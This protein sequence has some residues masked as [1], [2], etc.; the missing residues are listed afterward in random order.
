MTFFKIKLRFPGLTALS[1]QPG[2]SWRQF[3]YSFTCPSTQGAR[4][5]A[6]SQ[7]RL[8][9][10]PEQQ[11]SSSP[12]AGSELHLPAPSGSVSPA[13]EPAL[14]DP[15][16]SG[17]QPE[18]GQC[19]RIHRGS[20]SRDT[21]VSFGANLDPPLRPP[22]PLPTSSEV[23]QRQN[24]MSLKALPFQLLPLGDCVQWNNSFVAPA[25]LAMNCSSKNELNSQ[26]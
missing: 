12:T 17:S 1:T 6:G 2:G 7:T 5:A 22:Q 15:A 13:Q 14:Q 18:P 24:E 19:S 21:P 3:N 9:R 11:N 23:T 4:G 8:Q 26:V 25:E 10:F 20:H 16:A